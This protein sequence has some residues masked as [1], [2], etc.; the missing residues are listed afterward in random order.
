MKWLHFVGKKYYSIKEFETEGLMYGVSRRIAPKMFKKMNFGDKILLAQGDKKGAKIFG[1]FVFNRLLGLSPEIM[2]NLMNKDMIEL[3][4]GFEPSSVIRG[5]GS[6]NVT[7][8]F[9]VK[10]PIELLDY[11]KS[12]DDE[13]LKGILIG[14]EY[15]SLKE[16][17]I[18]KDYVNTNIY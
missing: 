14:G 15:H 8:C 1:Y 6:Y 11:L 13:E 17:G 7:A 10:N 2:M 16:L 18:D 5:C 9:V 4:A 12:L 3:K